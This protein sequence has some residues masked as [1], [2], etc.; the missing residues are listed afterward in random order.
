MN[1]VEKAVANDTDPL[2]LMVAAHELGHGVM[3]RKYGFPIKRVYI[4]LGLFGGVS[5]AGCTR[6]KTVL[7]AANYEGYL[8]GLAAGMASEIRCATKYLGYGKWSAEWMVSSSASHDRS[9]F[10]RLAKAWGHAR[11]F[12][13]DVRR[14]LSMLSDYGS[15]LDRLTVELVN[16]KRVSGSSL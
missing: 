5:K 2:L 10:K 11:S 7:T 4:S 13:S 12:E 16:T 15:R 6:G 8:L 14:A 3:W 9:E 1:P